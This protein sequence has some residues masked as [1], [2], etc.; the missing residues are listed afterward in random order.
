M[1]EKGKYYKLFNKRQRNTVKSP[2]HSSYE[3]LNPPAVRT[4]DDARRQASTTFL[5]FFFLFHFISPWPGLSA[6]SQQVRFG[7]EERRLMHLV[8]APAVSL[9][10]RRV[11]SRPG[12]Q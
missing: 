12:P 8:P 9:M 11:L 3:I 10:K 2:K 1:I 6:G 4:K 7:D 5:S